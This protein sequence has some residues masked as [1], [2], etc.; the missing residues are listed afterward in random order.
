MKNTDP[1]FPVELENFLARPAN[2]DKAFKAIVAD[3]DGIVQPVELA[4][5]GAML[6]L[7]PRDKRTARVILS[8][9]NPRELAIILVPMK[10]NPREDWEVHFSFNTPARVII[11]AVQAIA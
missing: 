11:A 4:N 3:L 9:Y 1:K 5:D 7:E 2:Q 8:Q 6:Y 10:E